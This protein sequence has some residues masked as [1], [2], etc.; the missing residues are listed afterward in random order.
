MTTAPLRLGLIGAGRIAQAA[1]LPALEKLSDLRLTMVADPSQHLAQGVAE[2]YGAGWTTDSAELLAA[3]LDAVLICV[4]DRLHAPLGLAA[5]EAGLPTLIEKP[6][7]PTVDESRA[8]A[9]AARE[10]DVVLVPGFMKRFDPAVEYARDRLP[11]IG[12]VLSAQFWYRQMGATRTEVQQTLFPRMIVDETVRAREQTFKEDGRTYRL[13]TH[14]VH[15]IDLMRALL[16]ELD[17]LSARS[18]NLG[19][20]FS[21]HGAAGIRDAGLA[22]FEIT[23]SVHSPW[24]EG[25]D[26]FGELGTIRIRSPYAF[27]RLGSTVEVFVESEGVA[28][29]PVFADSN[30]F[31]RQLQAFARRVRGED[32]ALPTPDDGT[33]ATRLVLAVGQSV[34]DDGAKVV[35]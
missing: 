25:V 12:P 35:L 14:G 6:L 21:W 2:R 15:Q 9:Q 27:T 7:A 18:V 30:P 20:D 10:A 22:S 13:M 32:V 29:R 8:L 3:G 23:T 34:A 26:L 17:W 28:R 24:S 4:P 16:G 31:S 33:E 1:H 11:E 5:I 19:G